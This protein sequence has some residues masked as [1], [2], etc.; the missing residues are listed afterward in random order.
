MAERT[1]YVIIG[2]GI[3]GVT[4]AEILR[5]KR[6]AVKSKHLILPPRDFLYNARSGRC[7]VV[8]DGIA[9]ATP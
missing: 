9:H 1:S 6:A 7:A 5:S 2:N 8:R 3:A 4:A